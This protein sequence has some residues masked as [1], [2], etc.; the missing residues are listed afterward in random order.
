M[1]NFSSNAQFFYFKNRE[2]I[3]C[4]ANFSKVTTK[5]YFKQTDLNIVCLVQMFMKLLRVPERWQGQERALKH[6]GDLLAA[7]FFW[8]ATATEAG[9]NITVSSF[10]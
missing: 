4:T 1:V 7:L 8:R 9:L 2:C 3:V 5:S 10:K 6:C